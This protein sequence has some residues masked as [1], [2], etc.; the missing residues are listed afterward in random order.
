MTHACENTTYRF[1]LLWSFINYYLSLD[2]NIL[3]AFRAP[4]YTWMIGWHFF[5]PSSS[6]ILYS[7]RSG[8]RVLLKVAEWGGKENT[9]SQLMPI[10]HAHK[11]STVNL[12]HSGHLGT[13]SNY[14]GSTE[15]YC[16]G[17]RIFNRKFAHRLADD[18]NYDDKRASL[19]VSLRTRKLEKKIQYCCRDIKETSL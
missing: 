12:R 5:L 10:K 15:F 2:Q 16:S 8:M 3:S 13:K 19:H 6:K 17:N 18:D 7:R 4:L 1:P 11:I 14:S 9:C